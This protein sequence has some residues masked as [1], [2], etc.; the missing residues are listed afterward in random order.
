MCNLDNHNDILEFIQDY[1]RQVDFVVKVFKHKYNTTDI[2]NSWHRGLYNQTGNIQ[3]FGIQK[4]FFHGIGLAATID[5]I[6]VDFDFSDYPDVRHDGFDSWRLYNFAKNHPTKYKQFADQKVLDE[7]F[8]RLR[9][10]DIIYK[11]ETRYS[12]TLFFF[13]DNTLI[14][15]VGNINFE[16]IRKK[17]WWK[18]F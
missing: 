7:H 15:G 12:S 1:Q 2:L 4:Y 18:I 13:K 9:N 5:K 8:F 11:P 3:E 16:A 14:A 6:S 17:S 10:D